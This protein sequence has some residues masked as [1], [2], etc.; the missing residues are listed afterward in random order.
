MTGGVGFIGMRRSSIKNNLGMIRNRRSMGDNPFR[1]DKKKERKT[2]NY[3]DLKHW[4][5]EKNL[6]MK[7]I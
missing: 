3:D 4:K 6:R 2:S 7:K 1:G 5:L